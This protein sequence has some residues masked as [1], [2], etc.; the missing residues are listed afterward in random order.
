LCLALAGFQAA[1]QPAPLPPAAFLGLLNQNQA[2]AEASL[3][4]I[5]AGWRDDYS[6]LLLEVI[7]F[8]PSLGTRKGVASMLARASG[9]PFDGDLNGWY[10]WLW[11]A[12]PTAYPDYAEFKAALYEQ[13][14]PRFREYFAG[15]PRTAIRLDEIR[16]G[17]VWRDGIPPLESPKMIPASA[18]SY[19]AGEDIVFG[20]A[21]DGDVRAYPK[22]ILAWH[23][24]FRDR[25]EGPGSQALARLPAHRA[26][27]FGWHAAFPGTRLVQ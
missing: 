17:G 6:A 12:P 15:K 13:I 26:F 16:W 24:M 18:A 1:A 5:R 19:L 14:D 21:I 25:L 8:V 23:E 9:R 7:G 11:S 22:R 10:G 20:V 4:R 3:A 2:A 27:W